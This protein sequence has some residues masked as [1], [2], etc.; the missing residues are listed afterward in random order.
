MPDASRGNGEDGD[1][2]VL[3][4]IR[5]GVVAAGLFFSRFLSACP[6]AARSRLARV[7][8]R[9]LTWAF[10]VERVC[11]QT[12]LRANVAFADGLPLSRIFHQVKE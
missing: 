9:R 4:D 8:P 5:A 1:A 12:R 2:C 11:P 7:P 6:S 3:P 10:S